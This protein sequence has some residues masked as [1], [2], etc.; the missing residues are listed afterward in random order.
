MKAPSGG[1][2]E[3]KYIDRPE[4]SE[5]FADRL[6]ALFFDGGTVRMEFTVTRTDSTPPTG[7]KAPP[8]PRRWAYTACRLVLS[9]RGAPEMLNKMQELQRVMLQQGQLQTRP[10]DAAAQSPTPPPPPIEPPVPEAQPP[11]AKPS[12]KKTP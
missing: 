10:A 9:A 1:S 12:G 8:E 3:P 11:E 4:V 6:E 7:G 5:V 2:A